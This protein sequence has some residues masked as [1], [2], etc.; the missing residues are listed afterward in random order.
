MASIRN[1]M[2]M[3]DEIARQ[4]SDN[5]DTMKELAGIAKEERQEGME[6]GESPDGSKM[7]PLRPATIKRKRKP[8][9]T[10]LASGNRS[11]AKKTSLSPETP[12]IDWGYL[13]NPTTEGKRNRGVVRMAKSRSTPVWN[14]KGIAEIHDKGSGKIPARPHWGIYD[15]ARER[16][17]KAWEQFV[18]RT[19]QRAKAKYGR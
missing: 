4:L 19:I 13:K 2:Q 16:I 7:K 1:V 3:L 9:T 10:I 17:E 15:E 11:K 18:T 5:A 6:R 12:L 8:H 14:G